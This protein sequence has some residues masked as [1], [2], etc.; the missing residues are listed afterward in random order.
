MALKKMKV[1]ATESDVR[2]ISLTSFW[3]KCME[4]FVIKW[5]NEAIGHKIDVT[6]YGGLKGQSTSHYL[7][8]LVNFVLYNQDFKNPHATLAIMYDFYKAFNRQD[9]NTLITLL[10]D[11]GTPGWLLKLV[12]AFI[13]NRK[14]VLN[15]QGCTSREEDLPGGGP[16]GTKLGLY[17]FLVLINN[18]GYKPNQINLNIGE[19]IT[20]PKRKSILR[21][22]QKYVDDM[23]QCAAVDLKKIAVPNT[24]TVRPRSYH[25]RTG[26]M[27]LPEDNPIQEEVT[28]L[29]NYANKHKMK[30]NT[31]KT[32][33][34]VFNQAK[35]VDVLPVVKMGDNEIIEVVDELKLLRIIVRND[36][37]WHSNTRNIIS[38]CF[39][40]IRLLRNLKKF[41]ASEE[42]MIEVY[43]Q[44]I[45]S[46]AEMACPVWNSGL[47][48][49]EVR[50]LERVQ[51]TAVAVIR[52]ESHTSYSE[53]LD[54]FSL[55]TLKDRREDI[56]L[57]FALKAYTHP[58][59]SCWF[60][61]N[62]NTVNTRSVRMPLVEI[63]GRTRRYKK[64]PLSYLNDLLNT[65]LMKKSK[66][67]IEADAHNGE[68]SL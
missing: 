50:S 5:L 61:K 27:L 64:S 25:E 68:P 10:S 33:A 65:H 41:G 35:S 12:I 18:A 16:Q 7:I 28:K 8:D 46:F 3:S 44:Q 9:H 22:Q 66:P 15:H 21:T 39:A 58:K 40:R 17:L 67:I 4:S 54:Y 14:M 24:N 32:K 56:C 62:S 55:K 51:R 29:V 60:T 2:I 36:M 26:H 23:T 48:H 30:V 43:L 45:R 47:T 57:K 31:K 59:F 52:G 38:K 34:M 37:K 1:P 6:Q 63:K 20:Q 13:E 49:Q 53:T 42:Q 19:Q 11:M